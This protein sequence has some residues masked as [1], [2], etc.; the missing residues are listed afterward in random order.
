M[1]LEIKKKL[2]WLIIRKLATK[3]LIQLVSPNFTGIQLFGL[4]VKRKTTLPKKIL[5]QM[6][7]L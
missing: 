5:K 4:I 6:Q 1:T 7:E 3:T 2:S